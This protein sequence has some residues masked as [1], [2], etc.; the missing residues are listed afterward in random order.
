MKITEHLYKTSGVEYGTNSN[1]FVVDCGVGLVFLDAGYQQIQW[2]AMQASLRHWGLDGKPVTHA[3]IT[4]GHFDHAGNVYRLNAMGTKIIM[5]DPDA[6]KMEHGHPEMEQL[7]GAKWITG[8]VDHKPSDG[9]VFT[10]GNG[11]RITAIAAPGHSDG[12]FAYVI[13][14]D[15]HKALCTGDMYYIVPHPPEDAVDLEIAYMGSWDFS[16]EKFTSTLEKMS[17]LGCD[18]L[19]PGHYYVYYG[20]IDELSRRAVKTL[21]ELRSAEPKKA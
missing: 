15:G 2:D 16:M 21:E 17:T 7:F 12:S 5:A 18:I 14:V 1:T 13:E 8:T 9:E 6:Y 11:V 3:F 4:H 10:F 20:D 19:L